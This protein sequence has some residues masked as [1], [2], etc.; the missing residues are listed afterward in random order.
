M[1][2]FCGYLARRAKG[3]VVAPE[4]RAY[5]WL[6]QHYQERYAMSGKEL[7]SFNRLF[8]IERRAHAHLKHGLETGNARLM[9][10]AARLLE[11]AN[12]KAMLTGPEVS[13]FHS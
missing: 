8:Y 2:D 7:H 12:T 13:A 5:L 9:R 6:G 3:G 4:I 10:K 1:H 11:L